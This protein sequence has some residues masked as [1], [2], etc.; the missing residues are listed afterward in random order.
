MANFA[1]FASVE[2]LDSLDEAEMIEGHLSAQRG[3]PEPGPNRGK[4]FWHGW[5]TRMMD[6]GEIDGGEV[7][8]KL[9]REWLA[10]ERVR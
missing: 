1:S 8:R 2:E 4:A 9:V 5:R 3:D 6:L 10:R 7:H